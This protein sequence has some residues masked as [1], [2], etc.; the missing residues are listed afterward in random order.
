M[1]K[2][3]DLFSGNFECSSSHPKCTALFSKLS[4]C[5]RHPLAVHTNGETPRIAHL[6]GLICVAESKFCD[7]HRDGATRLPGLQPHKLK[8][9]PNPSA[10][11]K[12]GRKETGMGS[13]LGK[14]AV[15]LLAPGAGL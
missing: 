6:A 1:H 12:L 14:A 2:K 10:V 8:P 9:F 7:Q 15:L 3:E 11:Q 13:R 4:L 5:S